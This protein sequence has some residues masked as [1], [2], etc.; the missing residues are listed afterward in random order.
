[1]TLAAECSSSLL[2]MLQALYFI[3]IVYQR[4]SL[5]NNLAESGGKHR[6][7]VC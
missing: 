2:F 4:M 5:N 7:M 6:W 3:L 1:M